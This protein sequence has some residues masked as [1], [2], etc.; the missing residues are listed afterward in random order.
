MKAT[1]GIG[2]AVCVANDRLSA[3]STTPIIITA[4]TAKPV[5][6][7]TVLMFLERLF[8][9]SPPWSRQVIFLILRAT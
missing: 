1:F 7:Q 9:N 8:A 4:S 6:C 3:Y 5:I 2:G